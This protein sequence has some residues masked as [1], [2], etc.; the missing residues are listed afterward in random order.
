M[1]RTCILFKVAV[2]IK[3]PKHNLRKLLLAL[4]YIPLLQ[5]SALPTD[6]V[7]I[8]AGS[9]VAIITGTY[10]PPHRRHHEIFEQLLASQLVDY[11]L[12]IP[13]DVT[14]HKPFAIEPKTR[15][16]MLDI[17]YKDHPKI[18]YPH[19]LNIGF[20]LSSK[21][22]EYLN[23]KSNKL[24]WVGVMGKDSSKNTWAK[25]GARFQKIS[26]WIVLSPQNGD[27][28]EI[29]N[30]LGKAKVTRLYAPTDNDIHSKEIRLAAAEGDIKKL[31]KLLLPPVAHYVLKERL[32][33]KPDPK[34]KIGDYLQSCKKILLKYAGL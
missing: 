34:P 22:V 24:E 12:V 7:Q 9:R 1:L 13:N 23:S 8:P 28:S 14:P 2:A 27:E 30:N 18:I 3:H 16:Q 15:L 19:D 21:T 10:S 4:I 11:V 25:I 6:K 20:P 26:K 33:L 31:E 32:Y 5:I 17:A 29:P